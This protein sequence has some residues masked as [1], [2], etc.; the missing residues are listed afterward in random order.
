MYELTAEHKAQF[1]AWCKKWLDVILSCKQMDDVDRRKM[2]AAIKGLYKSA[3]LP[4][5]KNIVFVPSPLVLALAGSISAGVWHI[6]KHPEYLAATRAAT[7]AAT[8]EA[9]RA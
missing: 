2:R 9:T 6:K 3:N 7:D 8:H 5:P 4:P 1:P